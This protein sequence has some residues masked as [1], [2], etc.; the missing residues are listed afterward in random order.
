MIAC[1][2]IGCEARLVYFDQVGAVGPSGP[3]LSRGKGKL[4]VMEMC[5]RQWFWK[6]HG[7]GAHW[8][9]LSQ[10]LRN[11]KFGHQPATGHL[12]HFDWLTGS[13]NF[14]EMEVSQLSEGMMCSFLS[15]QFL[16]L[17]LTELQ[18]TDSDSARL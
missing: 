18:I 13:L 4:D 3:T 10:R 1:E 9:A 14:F 5:A 15:V 16:L 2:C 12:D 8:V 6:Q 17:H 7:F 11:P